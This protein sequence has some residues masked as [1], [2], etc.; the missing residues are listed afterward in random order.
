M[1]YKF[2]FFFQNCRFLHSKAS[3]WGNYSMFPTEGSVNAAV[4]VGDKLTPVDEVGACLVILNGA[5]TSY[6]L[7]LKITFTCYTSFRAYPLVCSHAP[8][9]EVVSTRKPGKRDWP[10]QDV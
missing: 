8:L 2:A 6:V 4:A 5:D 1:I 9:V 10:R 3:E 7:S